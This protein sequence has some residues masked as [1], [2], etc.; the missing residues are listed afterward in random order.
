MKIKAELVYISFSLLQHIFSLLL[1]PC[2][3]SENTGW[4][5]LAEFETDH[6]LSNKNRHKFVA[7]MDG[8]RKPYHLWNNG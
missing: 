4:R 5:K 7:V 2:V 6:L 1:A 8:E 3:T